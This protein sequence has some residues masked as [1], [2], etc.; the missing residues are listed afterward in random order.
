[1]KND[2]TI[3]SHPKQWIDLSNFLEN[4]MVMV[5]SLVV[6]RMFPILDVFKKY[7]FSPWNRPFGRMGTLRT[8]ANF[9]LQNVVPDRVVATKNMGTTETCRVLDWEVLSRE[10]T[11]LST[12]KIY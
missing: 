12:L 1:M 7:H 6:F 10:K 2:I 9:Q 4:L 8:F 5:I 3:H 11:A